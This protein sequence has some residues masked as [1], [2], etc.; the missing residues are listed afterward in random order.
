MPVSFLLL[1]CKSNKFVKQLV[2]FQYQQQNPQLTQQSYFVLN[3]K[4]FVHSLALLYFAGPFPYE[5]SNVIGQGCKTFDLR[6]S[7]YQKGSY[8]QYNKQDWFNILSDQKMVFNI[9]VKSF[10]LC[11]MRNA[12]ITKFSFQ[13]SQT[14]R[15]VRNF[16]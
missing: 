8:K 2:A 1:I 3:I 16:I 4:Q 13:M 7:K 10:F 15:A 11:F 5:K 12:D 9:T 6:F 14:H